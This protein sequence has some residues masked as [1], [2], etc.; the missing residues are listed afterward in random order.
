MLE[1][2]RERARLVRPLI[3]PFILYLLFLVVSTNWLE[4]NPHVP[5]RAAVALVPMIPG[6]YIALGIVRAILQLDE[7]QR[8]ILLEGIAVSFAGT[9][10]LVTSFGLLGF[11]DVPQLNGSYISLFMALL[12]LV[13]KLWAA[14]RYE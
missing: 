7:M 1:R 13:G 6:V 10:V 14:R 4:A 8:R 11:A 3:L 5:W 12:W 2:M 9:F